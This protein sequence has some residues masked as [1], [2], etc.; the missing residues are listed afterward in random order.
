MPID[1]KVLRPIPAPA[2]P[3]LGLEGDLIDTVAVEVPVL[4]VEDPGSLS[5]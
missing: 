2:E 1:V 4:H 5:K 3:A